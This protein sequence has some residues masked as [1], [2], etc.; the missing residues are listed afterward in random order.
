MTI[1]ISRRT[2]RTATSSDPTAK[3]TNVNASAE[4]P[5]RPSRARS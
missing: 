3:A 1:D 5:S 4:S 2:D